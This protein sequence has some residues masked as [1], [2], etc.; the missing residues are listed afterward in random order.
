MKIGF[1]LLFLCRFSLVEKRHYYMHVKS[2]IIPIA[3]EAF[4]FYSPQCSAT[5]TNLFFLSLFG[6]WL[7][8]AVRNE[9]LMN[10]RET[11]VSTKL[12]TPQLLQNK[13]EKRTATEQHIFL[14]E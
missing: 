13:T 3:I 7:F 5:T 9:F 12:F 1:V 14:N 6:F 11:T 2:N 10:C 8:L 4:L